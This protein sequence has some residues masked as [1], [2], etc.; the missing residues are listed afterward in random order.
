MGCSISKCNNRI[1][2]QKEI[3]QAFLPK[4]AM[5]TRNF[6]RVE[7]LIKDVPENFACRLQTS[8]EIECHELNS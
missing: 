1:V 5:S 4:F 2:T 3:K 6:S 8:W 7:V